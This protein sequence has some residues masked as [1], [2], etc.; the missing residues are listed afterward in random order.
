MK[1]IPFP[2]A[3]VPFVIAIAFSSY[4]QQDMF[5]Y[6]QKGQTQE[7]QSKDRNECHA[8]A[9][10]QAG[11]DPDAPAAAPPPGAQ[12]ST[13]GEVVR[14]GARGAA[15]GA[16]GGAIAGDAGTGAAVGAAVGG[17]GGLLRRRQAE[18]QAAGQREQQT[19]LSEEQHAN[20]KRAVSACLEARG[21]TVK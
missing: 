16:I 19:A 20:Y 4:A 10:Q 11:F 5:I 9:V 2:V 13:G 8:W 18:R 3:T 21:Y 6:P 14:G 15:L 17:G 7:Q 1:Q 12:D